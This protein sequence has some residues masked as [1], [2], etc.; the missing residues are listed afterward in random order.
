MVLELRDRNVEPSAQALREA[1]GTCTKCTLSGMGLKM[2]PEGPNDSR[3]VVVQ[4]HPT[5]LSC[6]LRRHLASSSSRPS[7]AASLLDASLRKVLGTSLREVWFTELVKCPLPV[8]KQSHS[9][10][11]IRVCRFHFEEELLVVKPR[12]IIALGG[13]AGRQL[14]PT[15]G[16]VGVD[17]GRIFQR[18][19]GSVV[20]PTYHPIY[21]AK[22][23]RRPEVEEDLNELVPWLA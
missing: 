3:I 14:I 8:R 15:F 5:K 16:R 12:A 9:E 7:A 20:L 6:K 4:A 11:Q 23:R 17:R 2:L 13:E 1:V 18:I 19:D 10:E 22:L 21:A